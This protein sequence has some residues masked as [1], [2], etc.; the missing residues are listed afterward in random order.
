MPHRRMSTARPR[1]NPLPKFRG[2]GKLSCR[3]CSQLF[4]ALALLLLSGCPSPSPQSSP[5]SSG[6]G[7]TTQESDGDS[8]APNGSSTGKGAGSEEPGGKTSPLRVL[9]VDDRPLGE[10]LA[11]QWRTIAEDPLEVEHLTSAEVESAERLPPADAILYP[12]G[13][14][15]TLAERG[16]IVELPERYW[17]GEKLDRRGLLEQGRKR[18]AIWGEKPFAVPLGSQLPVLLYRADVFAKLGLS[19]PTTWDELPSLAARLST[20]EDLG[21]LAPPAGEAWNGVLE[22]LAEGSAVET[23]LMRTAASLRHRN[24]YSTLFDFVTMEPMIEGPPFVKA[25]EQLV[26]THAMN[27]GTVLEADR[28]TAI[29]ELWAGR[30]AL[31]VAWPS[32]SAGASD[33]ESAPTVDADVV[34]FAVAPIPGSTSTYNASQKKWEPRGDDEAVSVPLLGLTGRLG[35]VTKAS[36]RAAAAANLLSMLSTAEWSVRVLSA[37]QGAGVSR[38]GGSSVGRALRSQCRGRGF[39]S[40]PL[41][42]PAACRSR[43]RIRTKP[44]ACGVRR[45]LG[46]QRGPIAVRIRPAVAIEPRTAAGA[47]RLRSSPGAFGSGS[48]WRRPLGRWRRG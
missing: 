1:R 6:Q 20:R 48:P 40:L 3:I 15:G 5:D 24:Q 2:K 12:V 9:V 45:I 13:L 30:T 39:D 27:P 38:W 43:S 18:E 19:P 17:N 47:V 11:K 46:I 22:P 28:S 42:M 44:A 26:E 32:S 34:R 36:R 7:G 8:R 41:H 4:L 29:R 16:Y 21:E 25:L 37:S 33:V 35:S 23:F 31:V 14:L 10:E